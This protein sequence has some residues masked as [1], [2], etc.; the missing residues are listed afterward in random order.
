MRLPRDWEVSLVV[1][2]NSVEVL[3]LCPEYYKF[4]AVSDRK[5]GVLAIL[6]RY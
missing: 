2:G 6:S 3:V 4:S 5:V 1:P